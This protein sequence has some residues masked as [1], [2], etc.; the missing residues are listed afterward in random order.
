M[1]AR[2]RLLGAASAALFAL[3]WTPPLGAWPASLVESLARD[4]RRLVPRS[5]AQLMAD[6]EKEIFEAAR[7]LPPELT[8]A[9]ARDLNAGA[10]RPS[11]AAALDAQAAQALELF[12][13]R[14]IGE[15]V[16]RLGALLRIPADL[17]DPVLAA[18]PEGY[19]AGVTREYYAFVAASLEKIPV[20][21][22]DAPA[23]RLER[24]ELPRY[25]HGLLDRSRSQSGVIRS[26]L[27][28]RGQ[29]VDHRTL[30]YRS[31]VF[32]VASLSYSRAVT[33][34]AATWLAVWREARGDLTR[35]PSPLP[36]RPRDAPPIPGAG[37]E[38][39]ASATASGHQP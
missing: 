22:D 31:P 23:L 13:Q 6:R 11:T 33:G 16:V 36:V 35:V 1:S 30:D 14:R 17:S 38:P 2:P 34:I 25:W 10:L 39:N 28:R 9:L 26:E 20:V 5:L 12:R 24:R 3:A 8:Q 27:F 32:G 19:P 21:L 29:V 18:G 4:A 15:G 37:R 7:A